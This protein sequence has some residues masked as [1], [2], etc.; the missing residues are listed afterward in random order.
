MTTKLADNTCLVLEYDAS[1]LDA[2]SESNVWKRFHGKVIKEYENS[3]LI[4]VSESPELSKLQLHVTQTE[5]IVVRK[6]SIQGF[7]FEN[8]PT[9]T[10][11]LTRFN[12]RRVS[13]KGHQK[14]RSTAAKKRMVIANKLPDY[15]GQGYSLPQ[16]ARALGVTTEYVEKCVAEAGMNFPRLKKCRL[17]PH[18]GETR[19][20]DTAKEAVHVCGGNVHTLRNQHRI[21]VGAG[22]LETGDWV[23]WNDEVR[24]HQKNADLFPEDRAVG[25]PR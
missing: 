17:L 25:A 20:F 5:K 1:G 22:L 23:K 4:D 7:K 19:Y 16:A 24:E 6:C 9:P 13:D 10:A 8:D 14:Q 3:A 12:S 18:D 21:E 15:F 2:S 11:S